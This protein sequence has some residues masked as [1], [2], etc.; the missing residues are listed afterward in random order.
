MYR[1]PKNAGLKYIRHVQVYNTRG[2]NRKRK[3]IE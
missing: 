3:A 1:T 2:N